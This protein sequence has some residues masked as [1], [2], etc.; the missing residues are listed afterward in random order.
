MIN[1]IFLLGT[2]KSQPQKRGAAMSFRVGTWRNHHDGR[3][4]DTTHTVEGFGRNA[5]VASSLSEGEMISVEGSIKHSSYEKNGQTVWFT[6]VSASNITKVGQE[7]Q[8]GLSQGDQAQSNQ[9][10]SNQAQARP[11]GS[12]PDQYPPNQSKPANTG[13]N[14]GDT[15]NEDYGF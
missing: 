2:V 13:S 3:R 8:S 1:K 7:A 15:G 11:Q 14:A 5:E 12:A 9:A 4:F 6:S 10:Q